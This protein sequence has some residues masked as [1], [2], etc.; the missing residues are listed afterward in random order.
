MDLVFKIGKQKPL[1]WSVLFTAD[2]S[3]ASESSNNNT[4]GSKL[5]KGNQFW[6][7][8]TVPGTGELIQKEDITRS[9]EDWRNYLCLPKA[10]VW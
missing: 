7:P 5:S 2:A 3:C 4:D 6:D 8:E 1:F 10:E 9:E